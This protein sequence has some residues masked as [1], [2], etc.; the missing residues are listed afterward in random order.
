MSFKDHFSAHASAYRQA[1]PDY[2]DELFD[3]VASLTSAHDVAVDCACGNGQASVGLTR[4]Y[5][6]VIASD[7][8]VAQLREAAAHPGVS[9]LACTAE[10]QALRTG[11]VDLFV[12]AQAVHWFDFECFYPEA[13]RV[14]KSGGVLAVWGYGLARVAPAIDEVVR[15]FYSDVVGPYWPPERRYLEAEYR[16]LP[17]SLPEV[18]APP[19][20]MSRTWTLEEYLAYIETW[21]SVQRYRTARGA[22]PM[23]GLYSRL[24]PLWGSNSVERSVVWPLYLRVGRA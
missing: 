15:A 12:V 6:H 24:Q 9:L 5:K 7:A 21:S 19:L 3:F 1:R 18:P 14:L 13:R 11:S 2:P 23:P 4:H 8:S 10:R 17:F 16:T 22:D 20:T